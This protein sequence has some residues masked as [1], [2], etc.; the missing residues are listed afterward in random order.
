MTKK[1][2]RSVF[3]GRTTLVG[4]PSV[5]GTILFYPTTLM[6][7]HQRYNTT[8]DAGRHRSEQIEKLVRD[9]V[10]EKM[11]KEIEQKTGRNIDTLW[12]KVFTSENPAVVAIQG[13]RETV[14]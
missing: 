10:L 11:K 13:E 1:A 12:V 3:H 8:G 4:E 2:R 9:Y 7:I 6:I 14:R 5:G